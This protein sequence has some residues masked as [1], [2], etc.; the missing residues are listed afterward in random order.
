MGEASV[1]KMV[2]GTREEGIGAMGQRRDWGDGTQISEEDTTAVLR[3]WG[4]GS[5]KQSR[6]PRRTGRGALNARL[7]KPAAF[8]PPWSPKLRSRGAPGEGGGT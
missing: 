1:K 3:P 2:G 8:S 7:G 5:E 4:E 6:G